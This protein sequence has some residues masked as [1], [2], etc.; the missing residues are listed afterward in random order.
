LLLTEICPSYAQALGIANQV[1]FVSGLIAAQALGL[2]FNDMMQWRWVMVIAAALSGSMAVFSFFATGASDEDDK[3]PGEETSLLGEK[4]KDMSMYQLIKSKDTAIST[5]RTSLFPPFKLLLTSS[6]S[7]YRH[8]DRHSV[9]WYLARPILFH[10][11]PSIR[12]SRPSRP[13]LG[14]CSTHQTPRIPS[15]HLHPPSMGIPTHPHSI[16]HGHVCLLARTC[17]LA[18]C[19]PPHGFICRHYRILP[20]LRSWSGTRHLGRTLRSLAFRSEDSGK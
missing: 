7:H 3:E 6:T 18:Q 9:I 5:G 8:P 1:C 17:I 20:I 16:V 2:P 11:Y 12:L 4:K 14:P 13:H 19:H 15:H 10:Q